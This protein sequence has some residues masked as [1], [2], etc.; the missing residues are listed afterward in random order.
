[1]FSRWRRF[2]NEKGLVKGSASRLV[3]VRRADALRTFA[4]GFDDIVM[5]SDSRRAAGTRDLK[6][7]GI[8]SMCRFGW[9]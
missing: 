1:M 6:E 5:P 3:F 2:A 4:C 9:F 7:A 8:G